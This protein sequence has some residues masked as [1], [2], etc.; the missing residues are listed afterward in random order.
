V[1]YR[2]LADENVEP[3]TVDYLE[4]LGHDVVRVQDVDA[5]GPGSS[6]R[7]IAVHSRRHDRLILSHDDDFV[8]DV[9]PT[10]TAGVLALR[11]QRLSA[12][13]VGDVIDRMASHTDLFR[14]VSLR[15]TALKKL[16]QNDRTALPRPPPTAQF[17]T[18]SISWPSW[19]FVNA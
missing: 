7:A 8:S 15:S 12:R 1:P 13:E 14:A 9:D 2:I 10:E 11:D 17:V 3:K 5:L 19:S 6:D 18:I 16:E 4:T